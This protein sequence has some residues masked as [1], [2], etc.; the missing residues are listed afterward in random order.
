MSDDGV[1]IIKWGY[2]MTE[3]RSTNKDNGYKWQY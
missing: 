2:K 1:D 3:K